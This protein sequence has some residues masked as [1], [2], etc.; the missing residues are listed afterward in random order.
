MIEHCVKNNFENLL[1][2]IFVKLTLLN[3]LNEKFEALSLDSVYFDASNNSQMIFTIKE[4]VKILFQ[5][6]MLKDK[7]PK[8]KRFLSKSLVWTHILSQT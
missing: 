4:I 1:E 3:T 2:D 6:T 5:I 7:F 8:I